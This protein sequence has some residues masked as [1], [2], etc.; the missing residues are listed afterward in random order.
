MID[1][2]GKQKLRWFMEQALHPEKGLKLV[3]SESINFTRCIEYMT[4]LINEGTPDKKLTDL[5]KA[6]AKAEENASMRIIS[7]ATEE[8]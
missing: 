4:D 6:K 7:D 1:D 8:K 3:G 5:N 2:K